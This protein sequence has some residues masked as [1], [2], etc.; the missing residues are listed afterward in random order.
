MECMGEWPYAGHLR[1]WHGRLA[2]V[3]V[4]DMRACR[5]EHLPL[6]QGDVDL[7]AAIAAL[8]AAGYQ[9]GLHVELPRQSHAWLATA[10]QSAAAL[11][12]KVSATKSG[13][14]G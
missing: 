5:H 2:N 6:G 1:P 7:S 10:R 3:H 8:A 12:K 4:D 11:E 14:S 13:K 9:G